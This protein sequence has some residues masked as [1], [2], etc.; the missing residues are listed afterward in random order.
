MKKI[1]CFMLAVALTF[2]F[3]S[4]GAIN[5]DITPLKIKGEA[6]SSSAEVEN[7]LEDIESA[8]E[9]WAKVPTFSK[10]Q[11]YKFKGE[12]YVSTVSDYLNIE[13]GVKINGKIVKSEFEFENKLKFDMTY[14][15]RG[16]IKDENDAL[17]EYDG[18]IDATFTFIEGVFYVKM[19][20]NMSV[21]SQKI[22]IDITTTD[23]DAIND[24]LEGF[25]IEI[26]S[27][28][29]SQ[30]EFESFFDA[31]ADSYISEE[32]SKLYVIK[33]GCALESSREEGDNILLTQIIAKYDLKDM[34][35]TSIEGYDKIQS[36]SNDQT[37][38]MINK[39][40]IQAC[41]SV[42]IKKPSNL[43]DYYAQ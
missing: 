16:S 1:I 13:I 17:N 34:K 43:E 15:I 41:S 37:S 4:C 19:K 24:Y 2:I 28:I 31:L 7:W 42:N 33:N 26:L 32:L 22:K 30:L 40:K 12:V 38:L 20:G 36:V 8:Y 21:G 18:S 6:L 39:V 14:N 25:D 23:S 3:A 11:N 5:N 10:N 9:Q 29:L 35:I 27:S